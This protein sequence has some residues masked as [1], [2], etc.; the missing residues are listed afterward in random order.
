M[1]QVLIPISQE[2]RLSALQLIRSEGLG[3]KI[4]F[5][6][7]E[8]FGSAINALEKLPAFIAKKGLVSRIK[9]CPRE[10]ILE[11]LERTEDYG[12]KIIYFKDDQYPSLLKHISDFPPVLTVLGNN[13]ELL[14]KDKIAIV[15]SRNASANSTRFAYKTSKELGESGYVV[16]SGLARGVGLSAHMGSMKTGTIAVIAGGIDNIYPLGNKN[17]YEEI[18]ENGLIISENI[19]GAIPKLQN[20]PQR[21]RIISGLSLASL[22][23]EAS[24][25]S[26]SLITANFALEQNREVFAV[27]GF[28]LDTRYSGTNLL[29]KQGANLFEKV[30]DILNVIR[31]NLGVQPDLVEYKYH[32]DTV[33]SIVDEEFYKKELDKVKELI[34]SKL[35]VAPIALDDLIK[36][37]NIPRKLVLLFIV[38]LELED[39]V[40]RV[41]NNVSLSSELVYE[42]CDS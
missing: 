36:D 9:I 27:P 39:A 10:K 41:G 42:S 3:I 14:L 26:G 29:I 13:K 16:V 33:D 1:T 12:A 11:E 35:G 38:E 32:N 2:E 40:R 23:V 18:R 7:L 24:L 20:F 37:V 8:V 31:G 28:P 4:F 34:L 25:K 19:F 6:L 17:L 30:E 5:S 21:N 22:V 15:G